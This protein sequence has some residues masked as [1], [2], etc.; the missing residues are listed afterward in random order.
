MDADTFIIAQNL[1]STLHTENIV[2]CAQKKT[3][4]IKSAAECKGTKNL[5]NNNAVLE[6]EK[7]DDGVR[8]RD[9]KSYRQLAMSSECGLVDGQRPS[10]SLECPARL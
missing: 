2:H 3:Y 4:S 7:D 1:Y 10:A 9:T 6:M 5:A 8:S